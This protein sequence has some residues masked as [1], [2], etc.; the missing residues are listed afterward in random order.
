MYNQF[1][2]S[3]SEYVDNVFFGEIETIEC[4]ITEQTTGNRFTLTNTYV[5]YYSNIEIT[6]NDIMELWQSYSI[7]TGSNDDWTRGTDSWYHLGIFEIK[8]FHNDNLVY[9]YGIM[10]VKKYY[11]SSSGYNLELDPENEIYESEYF[12]NNSDCYTLR[13]LDT[14]DNK[15]YITD[16]FKLR[17]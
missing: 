15:L 11:L 8:L 17:K 10:D 5:D 13:L 9:D 14:S 12:F 16:N 3:F 4:E 7:M 2:M 6:T 1:K